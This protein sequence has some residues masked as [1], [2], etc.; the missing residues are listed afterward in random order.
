MY[1][2]IKKNFLFIGCILYLSLLTSQSGYSQTEG[3]YHQI[4]SLENHIHSLVKQID[5]DCKTTQL[6]TES[7][8]ADLPI[9]IA[10]ESC[11]S[12]TTIIVVLILHRVSSLDSCL[13]RRKI[14]RNRKESSQGVPTSESTNNLFFI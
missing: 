5:E 7:D 4:S 11:G 13:A 6:L 10:P 14:I 12:G 1:S 9:G 2:P 8:L 3:S